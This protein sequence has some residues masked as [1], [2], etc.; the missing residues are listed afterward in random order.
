MNYV[1]FNE[2]VGFRVLLIN[3][4]F[5]LVYT[6]GSFDMLPRVFLLVIVYIGCE[7]LMIVPFLILL[8]ILAAIKSVTIV[9]LQKLVLDLTIF[10]ELLVLS[11]GFCR[12]IGFIVRVSVS[13]AIICFDV[14]YSLR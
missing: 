2:L 6:L 13:F 12:V 7:G 8:I 9:I 4:P 3:E 5:I 14:L 10:L 11:K 1:L